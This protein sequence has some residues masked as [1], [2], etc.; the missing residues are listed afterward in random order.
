MENKKLNNA[1]L[2]GIIDNMLNR[3]VGISDLLASIF[4][5]QAADT[6]KA[7]QECITTL[8]SHILALE[9]QSNLDMLTLDKPDQLEQLKSLAVEE[10]IRAF[11]ALKGMTDLHEADVLLTHAREMYKLVMEIS[12]VT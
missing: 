8:K 3:I 9:E 2:N 5:D 10:C 1:E 12:N 6:T 4:P 7:L 11:N